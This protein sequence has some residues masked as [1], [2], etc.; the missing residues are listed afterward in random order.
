MFSAEGLDASSSFRV[1]QEKM[2]HHRETILPPSAQKG[3]APAV[4]GRVAATNTQGENTHTACEL[5]R[6]HFL[7]RIALILC[8]ITLNGCVR[9]SVFFLFNHKSFCVWMQTDEPLDKMTQSHMKSLPS[10]LRRMWWVFAEL[11]SLSSNVIFFMLNPR[12][13]LP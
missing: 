5:K 3:P 8:K 2:K 6:M 12:I 1:N 13:C 10:A 7:K 11:L 4:K 9:I